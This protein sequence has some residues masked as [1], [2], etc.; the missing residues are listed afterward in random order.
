MSC[1][2]RQRGFLALAATVLLLVASL[3]ATAVVSLSATDVSLA[4]DELESTRAFYLATSGVEK[5]LHEWSLNAAY[6]GEGPVAFA[7]GTLQVLVD[8]DSGVFPAALGLA[9]PLPATQRHVRSEGRAGPAV[10][11]LHAIVQAGAAA[12]V[13]GSFDAP[14]TCPP[15]PSGWQNFSQNWA[16][17]DD[18][19]A[20]PLAAG[21]DGSP[22]L[23][24]RK[25]GGGAGATRLTQLRQNLAGACTGPLVIT[26]SYDVRH[27]GQASAWGELSLD[28][29]GGG[30]APLNITVHVSNTAG[31]QNGAASI[32]VPAGRVVNRV[33][34][35]LRAGGTASVALPSETWMDNLEVTI[36]GCGVGAGTGVIAWMEQYS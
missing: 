15:D 9:N 5:G 1:G 32:S 28:F 12:V 36:P 26:V 35:E 3:L 18:C 25:T 31:W 4:T 6:A 20:L 7:S 2:P 33:D 8:A 16:G 34:L 23:L 24:V 30:G 29:R 27:S 21:P 17:G 13:N 19:A 11:V 22:A 10:R 14:G